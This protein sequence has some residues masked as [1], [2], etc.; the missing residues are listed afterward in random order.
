[1]L[2]ALAWVAATRDGTRAAA[3]GGAVFSHVLADLLTS[4]LPAW[5]GGPTVGLHL[6]RFDAVD[7]ALEAAVVLVGWALYRRS[8]TP[9][10][11]RTWPVRA[12]LVAVLAF[13]A[14]PVS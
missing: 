5:P 6:Y 13:Q 9:V 3:V 10:Q 2:G 11:R 12:I 14:L 1:M 8:L 7:V 4:R